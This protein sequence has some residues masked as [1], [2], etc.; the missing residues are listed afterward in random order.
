MTKSTTWITSMALSL[1]FSVLSGGCSRSSVPRHAGDGWFEPFDVSPMLTVRTDPEYPEQ[2][3][4]G[5]LE[6]W[7][8][9]EVLVGSDGRVKRARVLRSSDDVFE[10]AALAAAKELQFRPAERDRRLAQPRAVRQR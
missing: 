8:G 3:R 5:G 4:R 1:L 9:V 7:V 10:S 6:G 2:A